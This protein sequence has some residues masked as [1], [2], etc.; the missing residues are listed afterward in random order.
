MCTS[1]SDAEGAEKSD[2]EGA[3]GL[4]LRGV[5]AFANGLLDGPAAVYHQDVAD[6]HI[7]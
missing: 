5:V 4:G 6:D 1:G 2:A 3:F 7:R